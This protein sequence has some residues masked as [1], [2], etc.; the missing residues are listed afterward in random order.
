[1]KEKTLKQ[2]AKEYGEQNF[3]KICLDFDSEVKCLSDAFM[4]V[5]K[6]QSLKPKRPTYSRWTHKDDNVELNTGEL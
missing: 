6:W 2:V 1:M 5:A 4:A 3:G